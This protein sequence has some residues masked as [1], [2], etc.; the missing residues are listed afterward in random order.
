M[1]NKLLKRS[2]GGFSLVELIVVIAIMAILV[3]VA[4]PVYSSYIEKSQ[5]AADIQLVDEIKHAMEIA[6]AG[7]TLTENAY[8]KIGAGGVVEVGGDGADQLEAVLEAT[9]G[10]NWENELKVKYSGWKGVTSTV[11]YKD[12]SYNGKENELIGV[13]DKLTSALGTVV[14]NGRETGNNLIGGGFETFMGTYGV[15]TDNG[16]AIGNAAVLYVAENTKGK[17]TNI[18]NA[19]TDGLAATADSASS[20]VNNLY[21]SLHNQGIVDS[22]AL[23]VIYAY[24]EGYAQYSK[25]ATAFHDNTDFTGVTDVYSALDALGASMN[26]LDAEGFTAYCQNQGNKDLQSYLEMMNTVY[27]NRDVVSGNLNANDCFTDGT[28]ENML[29]SYAAMSSLN[30]T[31]AAGQVAVMFVVDANGIASVQVA[32]LDLNK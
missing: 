27:D 14:A 25:Q 1:K 30:V 20:V 29:D 19:F 7:Q 32:P 28:V 17:E 2:N 10:T 22:A 12:S 8:V 6:N 31:T 26:S 23:A 18:Q 5:K 16:K 21:A 3:G 9:F 24:A 13:V 11:N 4:V 15:D